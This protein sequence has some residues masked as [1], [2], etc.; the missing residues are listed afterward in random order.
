MGTF[1]T[2]MGFFE[3]CFKK[4]E[5]FQKRKFKISNY[6]MKENSL[7]IEFNKWR[8]RVKDPKIIP[9]SAFTI[10]TENNKKI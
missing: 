5:K 9:M 2:G 4:V 6:L 10:P 1:A 7:K 8:K 3:N